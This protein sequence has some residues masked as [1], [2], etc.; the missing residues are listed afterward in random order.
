MAIA[1]PERS[2]VV[3]VGLSK[4]RDWIAGKVN[5]YKR[6]GWTFLDSCLSSK[7]TPAK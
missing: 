1:F 3:F 7:V 6:R 4:V 2:I 5:L